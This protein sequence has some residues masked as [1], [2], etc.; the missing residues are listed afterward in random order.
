MGR[1]INRSFHVVALGA[2]AWLGLTQHAPAAEL[3]DIWRLAETSDPSFR[4]AIHE[5]RAAAEARPQAWAPFQ[6]QLSANAG[7]TYTRQNILS[8]DNRV[9]ARGR[10]T[11][12][13]LE[14][15]ITLEQ[16]I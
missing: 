12:P 10:S 6:P 14:Y 8:S 7:Y 5:Q 9:F 3:S 15:A 4:A 11:Y 13:S 1:V 16:S 2:W